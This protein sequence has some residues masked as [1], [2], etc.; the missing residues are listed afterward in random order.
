MPSEQSCKSCKYSKAL[1]E[2]VNVWCIVR[3]LKVHS[4]ISSY[5]F[6]HHWC[7]Q[8]PLLP[9]LDTTKVKTDQQLDFARELAAKEI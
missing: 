7:Q 4:E 1:G 3:K 6:C 2:T 9:A 8:E 5:V